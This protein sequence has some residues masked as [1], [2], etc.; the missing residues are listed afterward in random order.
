[1]EFTTCFGLHSQ[2]TRL[3]GKVL[4]DR[5][6]CALAGS[7]RRAFHPPW[8]MAA[9]KHDLGVVGQR[10]GPSE[11]QHRSRPVKG[12]ASLCAGLIPFQSPLLRESLLVSFPPLINMLKFGG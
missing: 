3:Y 11:T 9:F 1:M 4:S 2:A 8:V 5:P 12:K 6:T 7:A 10:A